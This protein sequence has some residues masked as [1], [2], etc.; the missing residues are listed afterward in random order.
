MLKV[1]LTTNNLLQVTWLNWLFRNCVFPDCYIYL[2][3][4]VCVTQVSKM[5]VKSVKALIWQRSTCL[6]WIEPR[7]LHVNDI[8]QSTRPCQ[9]KMSLLGAP[10]GHKLLSPDH[11]AC[12]N[13]CFISADKCHQKMVLLQEL[14][15]DLVCYVVTNLC[16]LPV[17]LNTWRSILFKL[18]Q[19]KRQYVL[20]LP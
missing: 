17:S 9:D 5:K 16:G 6:E 11:S 7:E 2:N 10:N 19:Q 1:A 8:C 18:F 20:W 12:S 13:I 15:N 14:Y 4:L 3:V